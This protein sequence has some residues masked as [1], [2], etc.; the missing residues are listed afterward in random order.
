MCLDKRCFRSIYLGAV[1]V[2][3][4]ISVFP[5]GSLSQT[6][7]VDSKADQT[8]RKMSDYLA[9]L[10]QFK[11]K[12]ENM[13]EIVLTSGQKIQ[14]DN[15]LDIAIKRPNKLRVSREGEVYD[16]E[17]YYNGETLTQYS[18]GDNYYATIKAPPTLDKALDFAIETLH[19]EAPGGDLIYSNSYEILMEDV[20][21]G[22]YVGMSIVDGVNCH[23]LAYR[24]DEVD[25]Q[26]WIEDGD[27]PLPKKFVITTKWLT[28]A[29]Q[30]T[31]SVKSW[32]LSPKLKDDY[33]TFVPPKDA[34]KIGFIRYTN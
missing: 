1:L 16:Q 30:Y 33:F 2:L 25:W 26:I 23:H 7:D 20:I 19:I 31:I 8:L 5:Q 21:S 28:G 15:Q 13:L 10:Q 14:Y 22:F 17:F 29:P 27:K 6:P 32:D 3:I 4:S 9:Q 34:Q 18:Q 12:T 24:K 11:I